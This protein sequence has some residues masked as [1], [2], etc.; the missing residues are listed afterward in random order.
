MSAPSAD[1]PTLS[2]PPWADV[3]LVSEGGGEIDAKKH[4]DDAQSEDRPTCIQLI[5]WD[6][7]AGYALNAGKVDETATVA[8]SIQQ[9]LD[10]TSAT[11]TP[12]SSQ[13]PDEP[14]QPRE[15]AS[16]EDPIGV[17]RS[18]LE[19]QRLLTDSLR[20]QFL[21]QRSKQH[22]WN[23]SFAERVGKLESACK[24]DAAADV[25]VMFPPDARE[26]TV[27]QPQASADADPHATVGGADP[28]E[29]LQ[30]CALAQSMWDS[31]L[32]LGRSDVGMGGVVTLWALLVLLFNTLLQTTIAVIVVVNM[33]D[34]T[35]IPRIIED[36]WCA[37]E[38]RFLVRNM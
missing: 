37:S 5:H 34:P 18:Q 12:R 38:L 31:P 6:L 14:K 15:K 24:A 26:E 22:L 8:I 27:E 11:H 23:A 19:K 25:I 7:P 28:A 29:P 35:F 33:G 2:L 16:A 17:L 13:Y 10:S 36:L 32:V 4:T 1:L 9:A 21:E 30:T 20:S 3:S